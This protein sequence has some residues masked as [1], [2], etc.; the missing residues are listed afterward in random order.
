MKTNVLGIPFRRNKPRVLFLRV[1]Y[2]YDSLRFHSPLVTW[3]FGLP[4][5]FSYQ[6]LLLIMLKIL[7]CR[8]L[9]NRCFICFPKGFCKC[10]YRSNQFF[11]FHYTFICKNNIITQL[12][13]NFVIARSY[14][15][16]FRKLDMSIEEASDSL[17][18]IMENSFAVLALIML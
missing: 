14:A 9:V 2:T 4:I 12:K 17:N 13:M 3:D 1:P 5:K 11:K 7:F 6:M 15:S 18:R 8:I 10:Y 16:L